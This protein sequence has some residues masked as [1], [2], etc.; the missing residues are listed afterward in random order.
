MRMSWRSVA[1]AAGLAAVL[2][3]PVGCGQKGSG[4]SVAS[5]ELGPAEVALA[6]EGMR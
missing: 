1:L 6:V 2:L 4:V 5:L 3:V